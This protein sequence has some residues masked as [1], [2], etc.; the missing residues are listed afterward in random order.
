MTPMGSEQLSKPRQKTRKPDSRGA[1]SGAVSAGTG[2]R[3]DA[4]E[5]LAESW[6]TLPPAVR[7]GIE[8]IVVATSRSRWPSQDSACTEPDV[9]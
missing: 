9:L 3:G 4:F 2:S 8:A 6:D 7:A 5:R 1:K